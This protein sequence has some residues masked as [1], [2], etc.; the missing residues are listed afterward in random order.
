MHSATLPRNYKVS[1]LAGERR[2]DSSLRRSLVANQAG[3]LPRN[4]QPISRIPIPPPALQ[5]GN[6]PRRHRPLPLSMI[7]RLQNA[8]WESGAAGGKLGLPPGPVG[9]PLGSPLALRSLQKLL[10]QPPP[11]PP[12]PPL[13]TM[14]PSSES[15]LAGGR[16]SGEGPPWWMQ[17]S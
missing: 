4:W 8:F 5:G 7:F 10:L 12:Q 15:E 14:G 17:A 16:G 11:A 13:R 9:S 3:T 6:L 1:A 2:P